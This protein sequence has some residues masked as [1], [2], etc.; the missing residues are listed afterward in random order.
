VGLDVYVSVLQV[1]DFGY[2]LG[3]GAEVKLTLLGTPGS[4][5]GIEIPALDTFMADSGRK[6]LARTG[7][8]E[9]AFSGEIVKTE[10]RRGAGRHAGFDIVYRETLLDCG[11]PIIY[12]T[13]GIPTISPDDVDD[14]GNREFKPR[15]YLSGLMS[16]QALISFREPELISAEIKAK[17]L[18]VGTIEIFP[19]SGEVGKVTVQRSIDTKRSHKPLLMKIEI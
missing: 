1:Q 19:S 2:V 5:L 18:S 14:P 13:E 4:T 6:V 10:A 17:V 16:L 9:Y 11:L 7:L 15:R 8:A 3:E 12:A